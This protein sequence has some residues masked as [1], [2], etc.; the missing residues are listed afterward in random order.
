MLYR[1]DLT[2]HTFQ[3]VES[4]GALTGAA[5]AYGATWGTPGGYIY[6]EENYTGRIYKILLPNAAG[7]LPAT[8]YSSFVS[9][10]S[11]DAYSDG[12]RCVTYPA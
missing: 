6:A 5:S 2:A 8:P 9:V 10:G 11:I 12:A 3:A 7:T 4:L 1:F